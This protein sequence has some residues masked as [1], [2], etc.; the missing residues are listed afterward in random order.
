MPQAYFWILTG[1]MAGV[2]VVLA[3]KIYSM[4]KMA[5]EIG[6]ALEDWLASDS[7]APILLSG[8]DRALRRL[9]VRLNEQLKIIRGERLRYAQ[10]DRELKQAV[11][12]ISHDLRTPL[13]AILG[14]LDLW[15]Q[16]EPSEKLR[17]YGEIIR[18]RAELMMQLTDELF[19]YSI[20]ASGTAELVMEPLELN[21]LLEESAAAFYEELTRHHIAPEIRLPDKKVIR[22]GDKRAL[23]RVFSN[24]F[25]NAVKYSGGDLT[26]E[27][28]ESGEVIFSNSAP[29]LSEVQAGRLFDRFYT[30][31]A[32]RNSTGLGLSIARTLMEQ[33]DGTISAEYREGRL[34]I[35]LSVPG[36]CG[37]VE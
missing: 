5:G 6:D 33:M 18:N 10:G 13:T 37:G 32:G 30:V 14:Y 15:E 31:E 19:Q 21:S 24:L 1:V 16:E 20:I 23:L 9:A 7:N 26:I 3:V 25:A 22:Q 29:G 27:L 2:I 17:R 11:T 35:R 28:G 4:K 36:P 8:G 12:N 34:V